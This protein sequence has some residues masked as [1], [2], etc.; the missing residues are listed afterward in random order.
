MSLFRPRA[1]TLTDVGVTGRG[2]GGRTG[3]PKVTTSKALQQ[4][5]VWA[6]TRL[7]ADLVSLMPVDVYRPSPAA[8]INVP[9]TPPKVLVTP[10]EIAD[11]HPQSIGEWIYSGQ[12]AL[13]RS[14][15][16]I[17][18][19]T[20]VDAFGLPAQ[21]DLVDPDQVSF[22][23]R[24]RRITEYRI[25][26]EKHEP[27]HIWH[28]RQFTTPGL[29]I[30]LS[31]IAYAA[32][33]LSGG[34]AAQEF[35]LDWFLNGAVPGAIL[36]NTEV[37]INDPLKAQVIKD[38]FMAS[39]ANG[40]PFVTGKDWEYKPI[41]AKAAESQF[42]EQM[43]YSDQALCRFFGVPADLVDV[44][45]DTASINYANITQRNLQLLVMNLG[46][47]VKRRDD[48]LSRLVPGSRF[49]KLNRDA[50]LAMDPKTRAEL[51]RLQVASR[52]RT[53]DELR[54][55]EDLQPLTDADYAQ[56][57][58]LFG[59]RAVETAITPEGTSGS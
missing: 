17:G 23:A 4:S 8:G 44:H 36:K 57:D 9:Q 35:A 54:A 40:D 16:N 47:A 59:K 55:L 56:F 39:T 34:I 33:Q 6:A 2:Y 19:I 50:I 53:P 28:E 18:V 48:A 41:A 38:R 5:V 3:A 31:P 32:L 29:P 52:I 22:R 37:A 25:N 13:D 46:G 24:G 1:A 45:V 43:G 20:K 14:G 7:R 15:N 10:T 27:R 11:G 26:G 49:V 42:I 58:R 21:I 30:G 12:I 51:F